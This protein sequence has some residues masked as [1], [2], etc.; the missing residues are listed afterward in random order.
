MKTFSITT[1]NSIVIQTLHINHHTSKVFTRDI[2]LQVFLSK[3]LYQF[4]KKIGYK[5]K[6]S[7]YTYRDI[8][9]QFQLSS[10]CK[11]N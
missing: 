3:L 8:E 7:K 2:D 5:F 1:N 10:S 11:A 9:S 4:S 6:L